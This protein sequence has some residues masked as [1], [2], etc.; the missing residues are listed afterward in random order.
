MFV[1]FTLFA[2]QST[3][4]YTAT[5]CSYCVSMVL[6]AGVPVPAVLKFHVSWNYHEILLIWQECPENGFWCAITCYSFLFYWL[7]LHHAMV[8]TVCVWQLQVVTTWILLT[9]TVL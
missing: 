6:N 8:V 5:G 1:W 4:Q 7:F 9:L 2:L 3:I